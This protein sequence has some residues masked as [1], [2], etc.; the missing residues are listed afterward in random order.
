MKTPIGEANARKRR[1]A[2]LLMALVLVLLLLAVGASGSLFFKEYSSQLVSPPQVQWPDF[3]P[4]PAL[5]VVG[6]IASPILLVL[7]G[8]Y[9]FTLYNSTL[10][11]RSKSRKEGTTERASE[12]PVLPRPAYRRTS[13]WL[14]ALLSLA[15]VLGLCADGMLLLTPR[16]YDATGTL[17]LEGVAMVSPQQA[18]AVGQFNLNEGG[19]YSVI[20]RYRAGQWTQVS[21]PDRN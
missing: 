18:W 16:I 4:L 6:A 19:V 3:L 11:L 8:L 20:E 9:A 2:I 14:T 7:L 10:P 12:V 17:Y 21:N 13:G 5:A 15:I 1:R